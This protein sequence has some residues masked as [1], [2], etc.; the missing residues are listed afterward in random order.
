MFGR[1]VLL[2]ATGLTIFIDNAYAPSANASPPPG[3]VLR[4][5]LLDA[6]I[7]SG[8]NLESKQIQLDITY[9]PLCS[10][11]IPPV[12]VFHLKAGD[13]LNRFR[14]KDACGMGTANSFVNMSQQL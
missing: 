10:R 5:G 14:N 4:L 8:G 13:R 7:I 6:H 2:V 3:K 1:R 11:L 9:R 12:S